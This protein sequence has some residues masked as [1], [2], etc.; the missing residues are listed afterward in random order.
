VKSTSSLRVVTSMTFAMAVSIRLTKPTVDVLVESFVLSSAVIVF[1]FQVLWLIYGLSSD[2][3][4]HRQIA[5]FF[6]GGSTLKRLPK[7]VMPLNMALFVDSSSTN[8][9]Y[10][11]LIRMMLVHQINLVATSLRNFMLSFYSDSELNF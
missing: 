1:L 5:L 9:L 4:H 3:F 2:H 7:I 6:L 11:R 8:D 10:V